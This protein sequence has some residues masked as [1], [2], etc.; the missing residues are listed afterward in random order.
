MVC[1][2]WARSA[3]GGPSYHLPANLFDR[4]D[5]EIVRVLLVRCADDFVLVCEQTAEA[6]L[7]DTRKLLAKHGLS[8]MMTRQGLPVFAD[9]VP[10]FGHV[11]C[12]HWCFKIRY[13][14]KHRQK[15]RLKP[16][17]KRSV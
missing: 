13:W 4:V 9:G 10:V 3:A 1:L 6:A 12:A 8:S 2:V 15:M 7:M 16:Y 17:K 11:L 5:E 14:M